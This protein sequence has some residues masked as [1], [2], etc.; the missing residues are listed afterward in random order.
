MG[1][2]ALLVTAYLACLKAGLAFM[3]LDK[4]LPVDR[5]RLMVQNAK[6]RLMLTN[7]NGPLSGEM[8]SVDLSQHTE[9]MLSAPIVNLPSVTSC[10]LSNIVYTSGSTGTP[11][12]IMIEHQGMMN[13]CAPETTIWKRKSLIGLTTS[14]SFDPSGFQIF[15]ALLGGSQLHCLADDGT[16]DPQ[17]YQ[18]FIVNSRKST[19]IIFVST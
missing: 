14:V 5:L 9:I 12:A 18:N 19:L 17:E 1:R 3:P 13:L 7:G 15:T 6:C 2:S 11:K 8:D 16:F 4:R 10:Q